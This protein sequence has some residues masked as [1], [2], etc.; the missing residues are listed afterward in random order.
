[1]D[2]TNYGYLRIV[3]TAA[4]L[5]IEYH[6]A[7]D[8]LNTKAPNDYVTVDLASRQVAHFVAPDMGR[9]KAARAVRAL[10]RR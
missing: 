5:R 2:D 9:P 7:S 10:V 6:S 4:Q 1:Y 8:G 3:V